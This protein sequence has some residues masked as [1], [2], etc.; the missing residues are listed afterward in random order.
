MSVETIARLHIVLNDIQ[1]AIAIRR[2]PGKLAYQKSR[3]Q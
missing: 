3:A 2:H 1:P